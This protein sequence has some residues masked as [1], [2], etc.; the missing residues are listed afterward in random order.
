MGTALLGY[1]AY[2]SD[3]ATVDVVGGARQWSAENKFEFVGGILDGTKASDDDTWIDPVA[4]VKFKTDLTDQ[5]YIA[6]WGLIGGFGVSSSIMWDVTGGFGHQLNDSMSMFA[7][8]R[9]LHD[10]YSNDGFVSKITQSGPII[11]GTFKF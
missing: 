8:Y 6:G 3:E 1:S 11:G 10:D 9:A 5:Y 7:G 4:G 2:M